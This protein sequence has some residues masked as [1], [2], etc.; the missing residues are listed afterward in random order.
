MSGRPLLLVALWPLACASSAGSPEPA[1]P[2]SRSTEPCQRVE[3]LLEALADADTPPG[4]SKWRAT[5]TPSFR[6]LHFDA[7]L[8]E[9]VGR[10]AER[11]RRRQLQLWTGGE[12]PPWSPRCDIYL[13]PTTRLLVQM[14]GGE[15]KAGSAAAAPSQLQRGRMRERRMNLAGDDP[16]LLE[17]TLPHEISHVIVAELMGDRPV[18]LW[19]NEGL[20]VLMESGRTRW[21]YESVLAEKLAT[22]E[23]FTVK[24]ILTMERYPDPEYRTLYYAQALS[25]TRFLLA[26]GG[27]Q[28]L[29]AFLREAGPRT[30]GAALRRHYDIGLLDLQQRW[31][32]FARRRAGAE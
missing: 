18:P 12:V 8:A 9:Q 14:S 30:V 22:G 19:A 27:R 2:T 25:L 11:A 29:L 15:A 17:S 4:P 10:A 26:H 24:A 23:P 7:A 32:A 20:A 21:R 31:L 28:R 6:I 16:F 13:Y 1:R 3:C 5:L